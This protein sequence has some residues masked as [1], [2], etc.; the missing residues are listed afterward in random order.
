MLINSKVNVG[1]V[2]VCPLAVGG[3]LQTGPTAVQVSVAVLLG[4]R[5]EDSVSHYRDPCSSM[6]AAALF[7]AARNW[8]QFECPSAEEWIMKVWSIFS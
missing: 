4:M 1:K 6:P 7:T 8:N 2:D 5:P 3:G